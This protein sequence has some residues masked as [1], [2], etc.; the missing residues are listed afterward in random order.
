MYLIMQVN[1][2]DEWAEGANAV[3]IELTKQNIKY[4]LDRIKI[5]RG[6][7]KADSEFYS[8][9]YWYFADWTKYTVTPIA[10]GEPELK[11]ATPTYEGDEDL[12]VDLQTLVVYDDRVQLKCNIK[13][14]N[15][16]LYANNLTEAFLKKAYKALTCKPANLDTFLHDNDEIIKALAK[17]RIKN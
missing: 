16:E 17:S 9:K 1:C 7:K 2:D 5:A 13:D 12:R 10:D 15:V 8:L 11:D 6:M 14:T 4:F 3:S